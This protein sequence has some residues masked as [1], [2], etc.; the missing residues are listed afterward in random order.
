MFEV[1]ATVTRSR[2]CSDGEGAR[3]PGE[4]LRHVSERRLSPVCSSL[5]PV[6]CLLSL[7]RG[8]PGVRG[9]RNH[10]SDVRHSVA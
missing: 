2:C 7:E 9:K 6:S 8:L 3:A 1:A 5:F 4:S 10:V